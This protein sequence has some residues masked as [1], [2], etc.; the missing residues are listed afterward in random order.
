MPVL[1]LRC[2]SGSTKL[3]GRGSLWCIPKYGF[4][5]APLWVI[6]HALLSSSGL[7]GVYLARAGGGAE[8]H[9]VL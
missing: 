8:A 7:L 9:Q 3:L 6:P 5:T 1:C 2:D 4:T